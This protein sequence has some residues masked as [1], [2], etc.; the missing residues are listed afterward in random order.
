MKKEAAD[1]RKAAE[2]TT[3]RTDL[4]LFTVF[5][6]EN[7]YYYVVIFERTKKNKKAKHRRGKNSCTIVYY[8][9]CSKNDVDF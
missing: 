7:N 3:S 8:N 2:F 1:A 5:R 4:F 9:T 6:S